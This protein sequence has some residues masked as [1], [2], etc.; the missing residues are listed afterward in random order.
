MK[1]IVFLLRSLIF[2]DTPIP[3]KLARVLLKF[4]TGR[5][6]KPSGGMHWEVFPNCDRVKGKGFGPL[7][8]LPLGIHKRTNRRCLFLDRDG[9]PLPDQMMAL[10]QIRH[11]SQQKVEELLLTYRVESRA[12]TRK[13]R[14]ASPLVQSV[15]SGCN[16]INYLVNKAR[17]THYLTNSERVTLLYTFGHLGQ[18]GKEFLHNVISNCI[19]Y[20]Y[21]YTEKKIRKI[22]PYPISCPRIREKH[23][24]IALDLGCH[25]L[26]KIPSGGYPS[27]LLHALRQ[28]KTWPPEHPAAGSMITEEDTVIPEDI[29]AKLKRYIELRKQLAGVEKSIQRIERDMGSYFDNADTDSIAT[30]Y[31]ILER[32]KKAGDKCEWVIKL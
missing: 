7:I 27:P 24:D 9:N 22:K 10:S 14:V 17:E 25:C 32:R 11:S 16:V 23:E 6:G 20:D 30:E 8:K 15:L 31:G 2:F 13:K 3:A 19:N 5:T 12:A 4:I 18:E 21:D 1:R 28:P 26:F 29:N